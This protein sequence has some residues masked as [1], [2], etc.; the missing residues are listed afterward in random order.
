MSILFWSFRASHLSCHLKLTVHAN[1]YERLHLILLFWEIE[2]PLQ[3]L[4]E[5]LVNGLQNE[6]L[7]NS[8]HLNWEPNLN[9]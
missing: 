5:G 8:H 7:D 2:R 9:L 1:I 3:F 6:A 4:T